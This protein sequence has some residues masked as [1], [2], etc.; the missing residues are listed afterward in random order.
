MTDQQQTKPTDSIGNC[1]TN[2]SFFE[3]DNHHSHIEVP[4]KTSYTFICS[5]L[6]TTFYIAIQA[7]LQTADA[8]KQYGYDDMYESVGELNYCLRESTSIGAAAVAAATMS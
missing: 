4:S 5:S 3:H 7:V 1:S 2:T 8:W 6:S